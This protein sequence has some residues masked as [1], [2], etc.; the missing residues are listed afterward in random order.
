MD[1]YQIARSSINK[2]GC[3]RFPST[4]NNYQISLYINYCLEH[5]A[6]FLADNIPTSALETALINTSKK[7]GIPLIVKT[8][9]EARI[10]STVYSY[11]KIYSIENHPSVKVAIFFNCTSFLGIEPYI[12]VHN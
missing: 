6:I 4:S 2:G 3:Y 12:I 11:K 5:K 1:R 10:L 8:K 7:T 9:R